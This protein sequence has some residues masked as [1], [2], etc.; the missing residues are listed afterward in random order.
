MTSDQTKSRVTDSQVNL[1][2]EQTWR[3]FYASPGWKLHL[4]VFYPS[5][6]TSS[7]AILQSRGRVRDPRGKWHCRA[8]DFEAV[9]SMLNSVGR[10][11]VNFDHQVVD[12][13]K[14][15]FKFRHIDDGVI[16]ETDSKERGWRTEHQVVFNF[17][18]SLSTERVLRRRSNQLFRV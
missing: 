4:P 3:P 9:R 17:T 11:C 2:S 18:R 1:C 7:I 13:F 10:K 12:R 8:P 16:V 15:R 14:Y 5:M 6:S